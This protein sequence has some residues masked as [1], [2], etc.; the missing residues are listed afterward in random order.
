[1]FVFV[2][3]FTMFLF[4]IIDSSESFQTNKPLTEALQ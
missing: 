4:D 2:C 3:L 1:M